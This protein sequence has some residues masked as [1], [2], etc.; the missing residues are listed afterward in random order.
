MIRPL[1]G[2]I[3][4]I[5]GESLASIM[6]RAA[7]ANVVPSPA[8]LMRHASMESGQ[9]AYVAFTQIG[10]A[11]KLADLLGI[12]I[13]EV[14]ARM[15]PKLDRLSPPID[16]FGTPLERRFLEAPRRRF[17]PLGLRSSQHIRA[18]WMVRPLSY[19]P[20]NLDRLSHECPHCGAK[21]GWDR[22]LGVAVCEHCEGDL[23]AIPACFLPDDLRP[24]YGVISGLVSTDPRRR[25]ASL[26]QFPAPF[27][28]WRP[29]DVFA[30]IVDLGFVRGQPAS[31]SST[32]LANGDF[33]HLE[34]EH[35]FLG[36]DLLMNWEDKFPTMLQE[37]V[38]NR[39]STSAGSTPESLGVLRRF[40]YS[41]A[42]QSALVDLMRREIPIALRKLN[43]PLRVARNSILL[44][45]KREGA[46]SLR[47][48][49][50]KYRIDNRLLA[51]LVD[52]A[53]CF[54]TRHESKFGTRLFHEDGLARAID[55]Y[56]AA[57]T[58]ES[59]CRTLG[60]PP[61]I[62]D[63]CEREGL[64]DRIG[65]KDAQL[66]AGEVVLFDTE[67]VEAFI[68][69]LQRPRASSLKTID[70]SLVHGMRG[71]LV[72]AT[73]AL[74]FK[75][76]V[77]GE[78]AFRVI[79]AEG[80][81][82]SSIHVNS[83]ELQRALNNLPTNPLPKDLRMSMGNAA[84]ILGES[85][86]SLGG[87]A[88]AGLLTAERHDT[89]YSVAL[90][91]LQTFHDAFVFSHELNETHAE[92]ETPWRTYV[93]GAGLKPV[94][95]FGGRHCWDRQAIEEIINRVDENGTSAF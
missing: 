67:S 77:N 71:Q 63:A 8:T 42:R 28:T 24:A 53:D 87:A 11:S 5:A 59:L 72:P 56:R 68:R 7:Y 81:L 36:L 29:G 93:D 22:T 95:R 51:R 75:A 85:A 31:R 14:T 21:L 54:I 19:C 13:D 79:P 83:S 50:Q 25:A 34:D 92:M 47:D 91:D 70:V 90:K 78:L 57:T 16:W 60:A 9:P 66:L 6:A 84:L 32:A 35:L 4:P 94:G 18:E 3:T 26:E 12:P 65:I 76:L 2:P 10:A 41:N 64:F 89:G 43:M 88:R 45:A 58:R 37:V 46:I 55:A 44:G 27:R 15:H 23:R 82:S 17:S 39:K 61:C 33:R 80:G 73:R 49:R 69:A 48:A 20:D 30:A 74:I 38:D 40:F 62:V 86:L 52:Q 1:C